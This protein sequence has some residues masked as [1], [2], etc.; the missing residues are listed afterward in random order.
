MAS[1]LG[2]Y[3]LSINC[4]VSF[5]QKSRYFGRSFFLLQRR[6]NNL[7]HQVQHLLLPVRKHNHHHDPQF[8][9][10]RTHRDKADACASLRAPIE[11]GGSTTQDH[12]AQEGVHLQVD[13][14][15]NVWPRQSTPGHAIAVVVVI[16]ATTLSSPRQIRQAHLPHV[17]LGPDTDVISRRT[18]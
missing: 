16:N 15:R 5:W 1:M 11:K 17:P 7:L 6:Q 2:R 8:I 18:D 9:R 4:Q 13:L 10:Q 14:V 3:G 12:V